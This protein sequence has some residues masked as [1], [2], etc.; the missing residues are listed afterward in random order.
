MRFSV[1]VHAGCKLMYAVTIGLLISDFLNIDISQ[2]SVAT[3]LRRGGIFK[4]DFITNL[5]LSLSMK[6]FE[7]R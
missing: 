1:A 2:S 4:Y 3:C 6:S 7:N 5:L